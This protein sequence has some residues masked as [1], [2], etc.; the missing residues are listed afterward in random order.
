VDAGAI[1]IRNKTSFIDTD[2]IN[3]QGK[4]SIIL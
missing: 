1:R 4:V 3:A 2:D